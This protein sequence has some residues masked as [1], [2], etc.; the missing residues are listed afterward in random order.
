M[1][2][3]LIENAGLSNK[4]GSLPTSQ[5][6]NPSSVAISEHVYAL[7]LAGDID[8]AL[9]RRLSE[10]IE[11]AVMSERMEQPPHGEDDHF[12]FDLDEYELPLFY[13]V[14]MKD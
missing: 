4:S 13:Q 9:G 3:R 5:F 2:T 6:F 1:V 11:L 8:A 14:A 7:D 12:E 10:Q